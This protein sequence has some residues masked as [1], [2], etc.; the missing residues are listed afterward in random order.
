MD[1]RKLDL[2]DLKKRFEGK[3]IPEPNS[4]CYLWIGAADDRYGNLFAGEIAGK[5]Y[6]IKAHR[7]ALL[8]E[9][10]P[11]VFAGGKSACHR[12]DNTF[13]VNADH[14]F[15]G[16]PKEN[17]EDAVRKGRIRFGESAASA[18]LTNAQAIEITTLDGPA[19][20]IAD[21]FGVST[22]TVNDILSGRSYRKV[23]KAPARDRKKKLSEADVAYIKDSVESGRKLAAK[24]GVSESCISLVRRGLRRPDRAA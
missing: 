17:M 2:E 14:L 12:C 3:Y 6:N 22:N 13:C 4:G 5:P 16:T 7:A 18:A 8:I 20:K 19:W 11:D 21:Q 15:A 1:Y 24:Y 10:G 9:H 23:T